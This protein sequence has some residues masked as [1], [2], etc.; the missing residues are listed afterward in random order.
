MRCSCLEWVTPKKKVR[1]QSTASREQ[2]QR[3]AAVGNYIPPLSGKTSTPIWT[4][5]QRA[6][7]ASS[8]VQ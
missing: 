7:M 4:K 2:P 6:R 5:K 3:A 1:A 8:T